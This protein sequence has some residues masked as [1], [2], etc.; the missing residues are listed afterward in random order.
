MLYMQPI[1]RLHDYIIPQNNGQFNFSVKNN[2]M[3]MGH[4][5]TNVIYQIYRHPTTPKYYQGEVHLLHCVQ[6]TRYQH[7]YSF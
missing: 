5:L 4:G 7:P 1:L 6:H 3:H 2:S